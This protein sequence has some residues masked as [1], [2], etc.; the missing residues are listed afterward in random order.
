FLSAPD[1]EN[2]LDG[3]ANNS[4][5]LIVK[6]T[7]NE[8][9]ESTLELMVTVTDVD[10]DL[11]IFTSAET[12]S[13][14]ENAEGIVYTAVATDAGTVTYSLGTS[15]DE[16]YFAI[17]SSTGEITF[18][19]APDFETP[20]DGD[21]NN[22]YVL[23]VK[24][25]DNE[26]N[27]STLELM[28]TV[29]DVDEDRPV[30]TSPETASFTENDE[31]TIYTAEAT[32]AGT[33][34]YSLGTSVDE[35]YFSIDSSTGEITFLSAPDYETPLDGD[36]NNSYVLIVKAT[37]NEGNESTLELMVTVT[38]VDEDRPV[39]TSDET[40]SFTEN[41]EGTVYTAVAS[42]ESSITYSLGTSVDEEYFAIDSSTGVI[43]FLSAPDYENPQDGDTNN[44]YVLIVKAT[45]NEGNESTL[46]L[47]VTVTDVDEDRPV[48]TSDETASFTENDEGTVYTAVA[49]DESSITY[50]LGTSV[51]EEYFAIDSNTGEITFLSTP[52][53]ETPLDGDENNSYVLIVKATDNEGNES[54]LELM[55]TVTDVDEDGPVFTSGTTTSFNENGAGAV[56]TATVTDESS[57]TFSLGT[58]KDESAFT[59]N[60]GTGV[61]TFV[62]PPDFES[63]SSKSGSNNYLV[64][65][66]ATDEGNN[67]S[68]ISVTITVNDVDEDAPVFTS[69]KNYQF[70]ENLPIGEHAYA[71]GSNDESEVTYSLGSGNDE[72]LFNMDGQYSNAI[73]FN[74]SPDYESPQD[75]NGD[76]IYTIEI[77]ATDAFNNAVSML[78]NL[79]VNNV[80]ESDPVISTSSDL[81]VEEGS[82]EITLIGAIG[83]EE[84]FD[85]SFSKS[86]GA[87]LGLFFMSTDGELSFRNAP[88]FEFPTDSDEDN[89]YQIE[90][91]AHVGERTS[92]KLFSVTVK[93]VIESAAPSI[94]SEPV[95]TVDE[96]Q[97]YAYSILAEDPN[98][99]DF[100]I[101]IVS[102]PEWLNLDKDVYQV[103]TYAGTADNEYENGYRLVAG[104]DEP[105]DIVQDSE[106]N[107]FVL[108]ANKIRKIKPNGE[109][110]AFAGT[111]GLGAQ[112][113]AGE[114]AT[115]RLPSSMAIDSDDN[116][117]IVDS[118]NYLIRKVTPSGEVSTIAGTGNSQY[119]DGVGE[120]ASFVLPT[121]IA[122][123]TNGNLY[124]ADRSD[125][126][127]RKIA[128]DG[129]VSTFAGTGV[130]GLVNGLASEAQ[131]NGPTDIAIDSEGNLYVT[132]YSNYT[133]RK[134]TQSGEV[135]TLAGSTNSAI[136]DGNGINASFQ[137]P[138]S[139]SIDNAGNLFLS[140]GH[141]VRR[142]TP[143]GTVV[144][145]AGTF[146]GFLQ[147]GVGSQ[148]RF[149]GPKGILVV[150][151]NLY[152]AD[153]G[154]R[155]IRKVSKGAMLT[156]TASGVFGD[157]DI[158]LKVSDAEDGFNNQNFTITVLDNTAPVF[159]SL[160]E[161]SFAE[162]STETAYQVAVTDNN[163]NGQ[164]TFTLFQSMDGPIFNLDSNTG[165]LTFKEAPDFE[166]PQ[167]RNSDN[168]YL[169]TIEAK[170]DYQ[171]SST[172]QVTI[173]VEDVDDDVL[174]GSLFIKDVTRAENADDEST[175]DFI[176]T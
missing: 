124:V 108:D 72:S 32:D 52:D 47:M 68:I 36:E 9:N 1:F 13:F 162:N 29:T 172:H 97:E 159:T 157:F 107:F 17:D 50:S 155:R 101:E 66:K 10:E 118:G 19:S 135:S 132:E 69:P 156:G 7:D 39:F 163:P 59:I 76:N 85:V 73:Y 88:D 165:V 57:I 122:I 128:S 61:L 71:A 70:D 63:P 25:T 111:G 136:E 58:S 11:P 48:F 74:N 23:I 80:N 168:V 127:I 147:D 43:T 2:P 45:D 164:V 120:S 67:E 78:V 84:G 150:N 126:R 22:S 82:T 98:N 46:E 5:V 166:T 54:A 21:A 145:L 93:D 175:T 142:I 119:L 30:F 117:Y 8:G 149:S 42:D 173:T 40:A 171:N 38:D 77:I 131:F 24:A 91:T 96:G 26:G 100:D 152:V 143:D 55:V 49:S 79:T 125:N 14:T 37:D 148:V 139:I 129:S 75:S 6:A 138:H 4:Y 169:V 16:E 116:I 115:F 130:A 33:V 86:G 92:S 95:T 112:D 62:S 51:D 99:D 3:D 56:Y 134:I 110:I 60:S 174:E 161:V 90:I 65:I 141:A 140:D 176:F 114:Q 28:V 105:R 137:R 160:A 64:D 18:L 158:E 102:G 44:S 103:I 153:E 35:E 12:A 133:I 89:V 121:G 104:F 151:N 106:G 20:L 94:I 27:E 83:F 146:Q 167:D 113:G 15:V 154:N 53:F 31:G 170:D 34:T 81:F 87:D 123:D 144:T 109:V 41:D